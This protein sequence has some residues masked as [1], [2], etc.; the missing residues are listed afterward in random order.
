MS[1]VCDLFKSGV[2]FHTVPSVSGTATLD[3]FTFSCRG[4]K[5]EGTRFNRDP[6]QDGSEPLN[7]VIK[8]FKGNTSQIIYTGSKN[9]ATT[10]STYY[11]N[12][13]SLDHSTFRSQYFS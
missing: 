6:N 3:D 12:P 13:G 10:G 9:A 8:Q 1:L 7:Y 4:W 5:D 11:H 2:S